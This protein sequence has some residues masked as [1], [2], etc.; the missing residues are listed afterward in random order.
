ME[1][2]NRWSRFRFPDETTFSSIAFAAS[3][4]EKNE[5][6]EWAVFYVPENL[7]GETQTQGGNKS[8]AQLPPMRLWW[9]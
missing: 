3:D 7:Q 9:I 1:R 4:L 5:D 2:E 6:K 8:D